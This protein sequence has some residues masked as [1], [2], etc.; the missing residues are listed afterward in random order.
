MWVLLFI[1]IL[2]GLIWGLI[3]GNNFGDV[4]LDFNNWLYFL[5]VLPIF[6]LAK[7]EEFRQNILSVLVACVAWLGIK[8]LILLY[9]FSHSFEW[10][11]PELYKW[12]R[13]TRVGEI[14]PA[15]AGFYRVFIQS[16]IFSLLFFF[17]LLWQDYK[18]KNYVLQI[19]CLST[20]LLSF[21]RSY[22][23]GLVFGLGM[24]FLTLI[25]LKK[26]F[27]DILKLFGK[28]VLVA[29][30]S[31]AI[32]YLIT[33]L[34]PGGGRIDLAGLFGKRA[35][36]ME[37]A[38]S[39]RMAQLE[40]LTKEIIKHPVIGSGF[41]TT[42]TYL[43]DDPRIVPETA[44]GSGEFTTYAFEWGYLDMILKFGLVGLIIYMILI[45]NILKGLLISKKNSLFPV[46]GSRLNLGFSS[47]L[48]ALLVVNIFSPY[49]NHPLGIGFIILA[50]IFSYE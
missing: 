2:C 28:I 30:V 4:F 37:A 21:S 24:F 14:T 47:A 39:S 48:V 43:S 38:S 9:I 13:D 40:P 41:G 45:F 6:S 1:V 18:N 42:V 31:L 44:G 23:L 36:E 33:T 8:S 3:Q 10:A 32:V 49:L 26:R 50:S 17:V 20:I 12:V 46:P 11:L 27:L 19:I 25:F 16:Q 29:I 7:Q 5:L 15:G 34:P 35:T 22:W